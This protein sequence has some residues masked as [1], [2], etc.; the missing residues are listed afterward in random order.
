MQAAFGK[1]A[2]ITIRTDDIAKMNS[3]KKVDVALPVEF[4]EKLERMRYSKATGDNYV[5]QFQKFLEHIH[6]K[7]A[8]E[9]GE[10]DIKD[11]LLYLVKTK[12]VSVSAQNQAINSIKFYL[13]QEQQGE[14]KIYYAERPRKE[15]KLP[16]VLSEEEIKALFENT[17]NIKHK[18]ILFL[19]Y[20]GGLRMS[21]ILNL[22]WDDID[23]SRSV[24][25][26]RNGKGK[27]DR[28]T[29]LSQLAYG[30]LQQYRKVY[31]PAVWVFEGGV[32]KPYSARSINKIIKRS[33]GLSGISKNISAHTLRHSFATHLLERGTD[34]RYIQT[35]LGHESSKTTERYAHVTKRGFDKLISP[36][37][38]LMSGSN[39]DTDK[40]NR[41]I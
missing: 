1:Y 9:I 35:L 26:I 3:K 20:S 34:L 24:I 25:N 27:K 39:F 31:K 37:D 11:Y 23:A 21:E 2:Q 13:E 29:L 12:A 15:I 36:L 4:T 17:R 30:Y 40:T 5:I 41:G 38:S 33:S 32:G 16:T 14:H 10:K 7:T 18:A 19:I 22:K 6:P 28:I 8:T